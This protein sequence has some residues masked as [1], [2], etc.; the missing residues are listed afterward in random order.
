MIIEDRGGAWNVIGKRI[1]IVPE[2]P[3]P[4]KTPTAVPIKQ[5]TKQ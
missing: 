4:G 3:I 2:G 5:P 1:A